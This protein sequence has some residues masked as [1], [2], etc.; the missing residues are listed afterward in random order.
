MNHINK[1]IL[2]ILCIALLGASQLYS[3]TAQQLAGQKKEREIKTL[4]DKGADMSKADMITV[5][6]KLIVL[7]QVTPKK[8][9]EFLQSIAKNSS[10][11]ELFKYL[12]KS[13]KIIDRKTGKLITKKDAPGLAKKLADLTKEN[14][15]SNDTPKN[16]KV[17]QKAIEEVANDVRKATG[18]DEPTNMVDLAEDN[19]PDQKK[20]IDEASDVPLDV[21]INNET[22]NLLDDLNIEKVMETIPTSKKEVAPEIITNLINLSEETRK[23]ITNLEKIKI[24]AEKFKSFQLV[25]KTIQ[26]F[27]GEL[28]KYIG[29]LPDN[30][31]N[32]FTATRS[33]ALEDFKVILADS[34]KGALDPIITKGYLRKSYIKTDYDLFNDAI[35]NKQVLDKEA[36][37]KAFQDI[38]PQLEAVNEMLKQIRSVVFNGKYNFS[39]K[40][41]NAIFGITNPFE[42]EEEF[43]INKATSESLVGLIVKFCEY[44]YKLLKPENKTDNIATKIDALYKNFEKI[45]KYTV[46]DYQNNPIY[47][48]VTKLIEGYEIVN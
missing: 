10:L 24:L 14:L 19:E 12:K 41:Y 9:D 20:R 43:D 17:K 30:F 46:A 22:Q 38:M 8:A 44:R 4:L 32:S 5:E 15:T 7:S 13:V 42:R 37:E 28:D 25:Q 23:A 3:I 29:Q 34:I 33:K 18:S 40:L 39:D 31:R 11:K 1:T 16:K 48:A 47:I 36:I 27:S 26:D 45:M 6:K 2:I 35:K 21:D